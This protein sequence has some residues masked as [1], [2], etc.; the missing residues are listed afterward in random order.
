[1]DS[2]A[3]QH[4]TTILKRARAG[5]PHAGGDLLPLVYHELRRLAGAMMARTPPGNTLQPT[6]LVHEAFLRL[7][8]SDAQDWN[9]RGHFFGAAAQAMRQ[10]LCDQARRKAR[11]KH[12][13]ARQRVDLDE[14][15]V[16]ID[17]PPD[18]LALDRAL[19][20]LREQD[21]RQFRVVMLRYFA[22]LPM[23]DIAKALG[24]SEPT[25]KR[26]WRS[27]R[28]ILYTLLEDA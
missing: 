7:V 27:A 12:G 2:A 1:M 18:M 15:D 21:D 13:G 20:T 11:T 3:S 24:V 17:A 16:P 25:V 6:A 23:E 22:G 19:D 8:E 26:D 9:G 28:A 14:L 10:I 5:D 4:V